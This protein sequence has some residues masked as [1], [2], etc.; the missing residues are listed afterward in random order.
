MSRK[1]KRKEEAFEAIDFIVNVLKQHEKDLD[2]LI[3]QLAKVTTQITKKG[4][5]P[6]TKIEAMEERLTGLQAEISHL[7][8]LLSTPK[9]APPAPTP[10]PTPHLQQAIQPARPEYTRGPPVIVRCK[11]W[12]DFKTLAKNAETVSFLH[13]ETEKTFQADALKQNRVY[14]YSGETPKDGDLLKVWL[15]KELQ[16][17]DENVF[18]GVLAIG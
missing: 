18:E 4:E 3:A 13:K 5:M 12:Q 11:N 14:A 9:E 10:S 1:P 17:A 16:M 6:P 7:I 8:Q 15:A 2:R